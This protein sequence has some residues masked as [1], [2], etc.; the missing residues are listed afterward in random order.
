[1]QYKVLHRNVDEGHPYLIGISSR[2]NTP[3]EDLIFCQNCTLCPRT[4][5]FSVL[6][7]MKHPSIFDD[8]DR[9]VILA[10]SYDLTKT[11]V[12]NLFSIEDY[13]KISINVMI[14]NKIS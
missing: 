2:T 1:M 14:N 6:K 12:D 8:N 5:M 4:D 7:W 11:G 3:L 9:N 13:Y 10:K